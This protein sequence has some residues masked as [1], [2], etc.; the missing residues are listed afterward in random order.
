MHIPAHEIRIKNRRPARSIRIVERYEPKTWMAPIIMAAA[1][2]DKA[3]P[4][5]LKIVS[6]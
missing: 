2:G 5:I 1:A 6:A 3:E 4:D